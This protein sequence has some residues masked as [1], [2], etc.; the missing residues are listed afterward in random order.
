M[1]GLH[2]HYRLM[3]IGGSRS[4]LSDIRPKWL[5]RW[6]YLME[7]RVQWS[8]RFSR[9]MPVKFIDRF[10]FSLSHTCVLVWLGEANFML[11]GTREEVMY[12][13][14]RRITKRVSPVV[15]FR[16]AA[17]AG[18][19]LRWLD[20]T[21]SALFLF[22]CCDSFASPRFIYPSPLCRYVGQTCAE[23]FACGNPICRHVCTVVQTC[24]TVVVLIH[25]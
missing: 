9:T 13:E 17:R 22:L 20:T 5:R 18:W 12:V 6:C 3:R 19:L 21:G 23:F 7:H 24:I 14:K 2:P 25:K 11:R 8:Q 10:Y 16:Y 4:D 15:F 1:N